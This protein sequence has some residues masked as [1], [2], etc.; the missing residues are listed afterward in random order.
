MQANMFW[1]ISATRRDYFGNAPPKRNREGSLF[2]PG[3]STSHKACA[4]G[5]QEWR[6]ILEEMK[7]GTRGRMFL[8]TQS[9]IEICRR[10]A[11]KLL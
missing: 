11:T 2:N 4:S 10:D 3:N 5:Q 6:V 8:C 7:H 9:T 1:W